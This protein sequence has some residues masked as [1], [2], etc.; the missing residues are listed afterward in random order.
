MVQN[1]AGLFNPSRTIQCV[2]VR[3]RED[4]IPHAEYETLALSR[5]G[6]VLTIRLNRPAQLNAFNPQMHHDLARCLF[7]VTYDHQT[8]VIVLI[9][10]GKAFSA[11]G[12]MTTETISPRDF[13]EQSIDGRNIVYGLLECSKLVICRMN[14]D[15]IGLGATIALLCD[16]VIAAN[17]ARIGDPHVRMGLVAGDGGA[18]IWPLLVGPMRAR[19]Y[20]LTGDLV[21]APQAEAMGL[22]TRSVEPET[23][24]QEVDKLAGK[25]LAGAPLAQQFTK[26]S[27]NAALK[28]QAALQF[29]LSLG[30]EGLTA[31]SADHTEARA[32]FTEK[33]RPKFTGD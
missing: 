23:L 7:E 30:Y 29:D 4:A 2:I 28:S 22:I 21:A 19:Q 8:R 20:L 33:R 15:A 31:V 26:R 14:G 16:F 3:L 18:L 25:L 5:A 13:A 27:I 10:E 9:G 17:T 6:E 12:D 32:A 24:D 1:N 11:G